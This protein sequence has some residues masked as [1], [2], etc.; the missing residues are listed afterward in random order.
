MSNLENGLIRSVSVD[1]LE[2]EKPHN[3]AFSSQ[4]TKSNDDDDTTFEKLQ[5][6]QETV[7]KFMSLSIPAI[8]SFFLIQI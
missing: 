2:V 8:M 5:P 3:I 1:S 7:K 4:L 6:M